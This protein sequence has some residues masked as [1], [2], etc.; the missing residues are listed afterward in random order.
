MLLR[1]CL[2]LYLL[3]YLTDATPAHL[4]TFA[5]WQCMLWFTMAA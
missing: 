5:V 4:K 1:V 2:D 3:L